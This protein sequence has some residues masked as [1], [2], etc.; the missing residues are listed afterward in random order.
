[1]SVCRQ[2]GLAIAWRSRQRAPATAGDGTTI[3]VRSACWTTAWETLPGSA[4]FRPPNPREPMTIVVG[5]DLL[6]FREDRPGRGGESSTCAWLC[7]EPRL[8]GQFCPF[9]REFLGRRELG[10]RL[11]HGHHGRRLTVQQLTGLLD[12]GFGVLRAVGADRESSDLAAGG[13]GW[14]A[15]TDRDDVARRQHTDRIAAGGVDH[16]QVRDAVLGH[17]LCCTVKRFV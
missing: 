13:L 9:H 12:R 17:H 6:G 7:V 2:C 16:D 15:C 8:P 14:H 4:D 11:P 1:M 3:T 5:A 10:Q